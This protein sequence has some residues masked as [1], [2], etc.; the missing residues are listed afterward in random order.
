MNIADNKKLAP[1]V[2]EISWS[3]NILIIERCKDDIHRE[4]YLQAGGKVAA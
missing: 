4:F 1:L 3:H 2:Q